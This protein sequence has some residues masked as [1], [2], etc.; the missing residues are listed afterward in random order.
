MNSIFFQK[1][2]SIAI[3]GAVFF[4]LATAKVGQAIGL[5]NDTPTSVSEREFSVDFTNC[6][7][8]AGFAPVPL[9]PARDLVP[10]P[11]AI[12]GA[13]TGSATLVVRTGQCELILVEGAEAQPVVVSQVGI[14]IVSP[15]GTG[16]VNNYTLWYT[17]DSSQ[18][19][20]RL[21]LAGVNAEF[22]PGLTYMD[23]PTGNFNLLVPSPASAPF[24]LSGTVTEPNPNDPS[25]PFVANWWQFAQTANVQMKTSIP[26]IRLGSGEVTLL[27]A[28]S[29]ALNSLIGGSSITLPGVRGRFQNGRLDVTATK[30]LGSASVPEPSSGLGMLAFATLGAGLLRKRKQKPTQENAGVSSSYNSFSRTK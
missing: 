2:L 20:T 21:Q 12:A 24:T 18:L 22:V 4:T 26:N 6:S 10:Q 15:D 17:T 9:S 1:Q 7:E 8:Y 28:P 14:D 30:S 13:E 23:T 19:A 16:D 5:T 29:S 3:A 25:F 27:A 11:F